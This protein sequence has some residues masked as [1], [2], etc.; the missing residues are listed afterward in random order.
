MNNS[1][2]E[3]Y[4][5]VY[6]D[7]RNFEEF[8]Y[9]KGK[10]NRKESHLT[11][12][13]DSE[14]TKRIKAIKKEGLDP[15]IKV[16][17][18]D[19]TEREAFLIEKTLIWK[20]GKTLTN[21]SSGH[22]AEKFRP[23]DTLHLDL[24]HFDFKNGLYYVNVGEGEHRCWEDCKKYGF[25]SAGQ[26]KKWSDPMR[27][28]E[29]GDIVAAYLKGY[30]YVGIGR[31]KEKAVRVNDFKISDKPLNQYDLKVPNIYDN[32]DNEKSDYLVK[33]E[34]IK[35]VDKEHAKKAKRKD[36]IYS[37]THIKASLQNQLVTIE[38]LEKEFDVKFSELMIEE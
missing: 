11:D 1:N 28:F 22:F 16:I 23:H 4:V 38:Y 5:Y 20:L 7:P 21:Q 9:G 17:A 14:K 13:S 15:I 26:D 32:C 36:G 19:L 30:G 37:T 29:E 3:Y 25:L 12:K 2:T 18:K 6:I 24:V 31:I 34:W 33:I 10:G 8:Y 27:T 35:T